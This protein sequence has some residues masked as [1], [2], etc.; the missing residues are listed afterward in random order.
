MMKTDTPKCKALGLSTALEGLESPEQA[1]CRA[2]DCLEKPRLFAFISGDILNRL[3][4]IFC[5]PSKSKTQQKGKICLWQS[6]TRAVIC[7]LLGTSW[8]IRTVKTLGFYFPF[9]LGAGSQGRCL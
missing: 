2:Q 6:Q 1:K 9:F 5:M 8:A 3:L 4:S 7:G